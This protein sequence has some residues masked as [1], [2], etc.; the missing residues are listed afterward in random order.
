MSMVVKRFLST[1]SLSALDGKEWMLWT[2][3][4]CGLSCSMC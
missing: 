2:K 1:L 3:L 4:H